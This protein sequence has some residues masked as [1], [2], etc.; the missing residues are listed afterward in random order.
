MYEI[1]RAQSTFLVTLIE[2]KVYE[3]CHQK[4][5]DVRSY[6]PSRLFYFSE[7][8]MK[9]NSESKNGL[10]EDMA[11]SLRTIK[12]KEEFLGEFERTGMFLPAWK[13][14]IQTCSL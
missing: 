5:T 10:W 1:S 9:V 6:S 3:N 11:S 8:K 2:L 12:G 14:E 7:S 4:D 13:Y